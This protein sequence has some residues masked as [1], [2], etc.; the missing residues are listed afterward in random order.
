MPSAHVL[1]NGCDPDITGF[2][3]AKLMNSDKPSAQLAQV[4][5]D[6]QATSYS[7]SSAHFGGGGLELIREYASFGHYD[8]VV[9]LATGVGFAAFAIAPYTKKIIATDISLRMLEQTKKLSGDYK[10]NNLSLAMAEAETLPF[11]S[12]TVD[13]VSCRQAAHHFHNLS[14]ALAEIVRVLKPGGVFLLSDTVSPEDSLLD[15]WLNDVEIRRDPSHWR[16]WKPSEW[17]ELIDQVGLTITHTET[18]K[19][20]L[21]FADWVKRSATPEKNVITL[22]QDFLGTSQSVSRT[23]G[24]NV[25]EGLI[26]FHWK[27]LVLRA[28][29]TE[30]AS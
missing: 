15:E 1:P 5:F 24:I 10:A 9:D 29:K 11:A 25:Q 3:G 8:L 6:R 30:T 18:T 22:R 27:A 4:Q 17:L 12:N 19:V 21:E 20:N 7:M 2:E 16:D 26:H 13:L 28:V 23:F 14:Y